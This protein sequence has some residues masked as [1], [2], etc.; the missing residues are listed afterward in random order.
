M[1]PQPTLGRIVH[2]RMANGE[3][4]P[5]IVVDPQY[6][7]DAIAVCVFCNSVTGENRMGEGHSSQSGHLLFA[8]ATEGTA[9]GDWRWPELPEQ[10]QEVSEAPA[11]LE[12]GVEPDTVEN[13]F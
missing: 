13:D 12:D 7:K 8:Q 11:T 10:A 5:A 4:R 1:E 3:W 9:I 6:D 2:Y